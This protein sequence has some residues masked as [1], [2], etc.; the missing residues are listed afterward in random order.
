MNRNAL[1]L[2]ILA[3]TALAAFS[4][5]ISGKLNGRW[6]TSE[7]LQTA[8]KKVESL[9]KQ[10]GPWRFQRSY[11]FDQRALNMLQCENY[12]NANYVHDETG[13]TVGVALIVGLYGPMSVHSP[14]ICYPASGYQIIAAKEKRTIAGPT[15]GSANYSSTQSANDRENAFW[16]TTFESKTLGEPPLHVYYAWSRGQI[17]EAADWP[18]FEFGGV[19]ALY[20][21]QVSSNYER[22]NETKEDNPCR[23]FLQD[24]LPVWQSHFVE[25][26]KP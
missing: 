20:K 7:V 10:I 8:G 2:A 17:W 12:V 1:I 25:S 19:P 18:R 24:F 11:E 14:E 15:G 4:G 13:E 9:P 26:K 22:N 6:G 21:L 23:R 3:A 5:A 16:V